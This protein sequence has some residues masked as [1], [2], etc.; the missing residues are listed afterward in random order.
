MGRPTPETGGGTPHNQGLSEFKPLAKE[1]QVGWGV[2]KPEEPKQ[3]PA[4]PELEAYRRTLKEPIESTVFKNPIRVPRP[5]PQN[6]GE[7]RGG[8]EP[9]KPNPAEQQAR[10][11]LSKPP[12]EEAG[13][14]HDPQLRELV[15][16]LFGD[17]TD[18]GVTEF[19]AIAMQDYPDLPPDEA[20][21][22]LDRRGRRGLSFP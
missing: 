14:E 1:R 15:K 10:E 20:L 6:P 4:D 5:L 17:V 22:K 16:E 11:R 7:Q 21:K 12:P 9:S 8:T 19:I 13:P 18:Q 2:K 3:Q